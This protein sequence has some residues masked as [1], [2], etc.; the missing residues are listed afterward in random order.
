MLGKLPARHDPATL[1]LAKYTAAM[2][3][4]PAQTDRLSQRQFTWPMFANDTVGDCTCA[5][6]AHMTQFWSGLVGAEASFTDADV[7]GMYSAITGYNPA[8]PSTDKGAVELDVLKY[9]QTTGLQGHKLAAFAAIDVTNQ[10]SVQQSI[11]LFDGAYLGVALPV[12]AQGKD[13]WDVV[14]GAGSAGFPGS[15]GGHAVNAVDYTP[16]GVTVITWGKPLLMTWRFWST[17]VDEAYAIISPDAFNNNN[18]D[19]EGFNVAALQADLA[20]LAKSPED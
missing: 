14:P 8:D 18:L 5:A 19:F 10:E 20:L 2:P 15:W 3:P 7:L 13:V 12:T 9:W 6:V 1:R 11:Y 16:A 4:T 17:Y